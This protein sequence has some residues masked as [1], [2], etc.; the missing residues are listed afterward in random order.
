MM[1]WILL[2]LAIDDPVAL[3]HPT[4]LVCWRQRSE[5]ETVGVVIEARVANA[6]NV[7]MDLL[8]AQKYQNLT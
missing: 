5:S 7:Q 1:V 2:L 8:I 4:A 6:R 3:L